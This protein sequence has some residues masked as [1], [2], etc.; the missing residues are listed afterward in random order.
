MRPPVSVIHR[1]TR[2]VTSEMGIGSK[3]ANEEVGKPGLTD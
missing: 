2:Q 3:K 1:V